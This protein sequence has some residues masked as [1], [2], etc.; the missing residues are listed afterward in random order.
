MLQINPSDRPSASILSTEFSHECQVI[1][2]N[3]FNVGT[4]SSSITVSAISDDT[5]QTQLMVQNLQFIISNS[6]HSTPI[7]PSHR[8]I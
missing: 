3:H 1:Q 5:E 7:L 4:V 8:R 6:E 2:V